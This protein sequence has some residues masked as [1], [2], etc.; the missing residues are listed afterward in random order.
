[1]ADMYIANGRSKGEGSCIGV[2]SLIKSVQEGVRL[3]LLSFQCAL[4]TLHAASCLLGGSLEWDW[5]GWL[6][7]LLWQV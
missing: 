4:L 2:L 1:M 7:G 3:Q 6:R 5:F